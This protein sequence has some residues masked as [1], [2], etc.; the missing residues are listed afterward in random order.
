MLLERQ[1]CNSVCTTNS[2]CDLGESSCLFVPQFPYLCPKDVED[3]FWHASANWDRDSLGWLCLGVLAV[4]L[5]LPAHPKETE[6]QAGE[7]SR[8]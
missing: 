6:A 8:P 7:S 5:A 2:V 1:V 4:T 3:L